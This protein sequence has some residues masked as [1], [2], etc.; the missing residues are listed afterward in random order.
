[1]KFFNRKNPE[2]KIKKEERFFIR[3]IGEDWITLVKL[4]RT[5]YDKHDIEIVDDLAGIGGEEKAVVKVY[6]EGTMDDYLNAMI[7]LSTKYGIDRVKED[8]EDPE[9]ETE[10][11]NK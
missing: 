4:L 7:D 2:T 9:P 6:F 1:M 5:D 10:T 3:V 8:T 11:K